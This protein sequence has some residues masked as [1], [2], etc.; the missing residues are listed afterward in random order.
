MTEL[1]STIDNIQLET[2]KIH[3]LNTYIYQILKSGNQQKSSDLLYNIT[4]ILDKIFSHKYGLILSFSSITSNKFELYDAFSHLLTPILGNNENLLWI[5]LHN[6]Q[7][8]SS[9]LNNYIIVDTKQ[10]SSYF[11]YLFM[12]KDQLAVS[13]I[14]SMS[15]RSNLKILENGNKENEGKLRLTPFELYVVYLLKY[16][17]SMSNENRLVDKQDEFFNVNEK[18]FI[19]EYSKHLRLSYNSNLSIESNLLFNSFSELMKYLIINE[20]YFQRHLN[21]LL[22]AANIFL[23]SEPFQINSNSNMI[24]DKQTMPSRLLLS[25]VENLLLILI[26][27]IFSHSFINNK[28]TFI[29]LPTE[30]SEILFLSFRFS[31]FHFIKQSLQSYSYFYLNHNYNHDI[32]YILKILLLY[33]HPWKAFVDNS[34]ITTIMTTD[35]FRKYFERNVFFYI[36]LVQDC[37]LC[38]SKTR[39]TFFE[40][41][42]TF[43]LDF[44]FEIVVSELV[45][46]YLVVEKSGVNS[47][48]F[49]NFN[50]NS[51]LSDL[52]PAC[53][54][55]FLFN[56]FDFNAVK[57]FVN[58]K[59]A[60]QH[61]IKLFSSN[62][63]QLN[64][65]LKQILPLL[66]EDNHLVVK[67]YIIKTI[68]SSDSS[69]SKFPYEKLCLL[70]GIDF[71]SLKTST[72]QNKNQ[73]SFY[74][75]ENKQKIRLNRLNSNPWD[76][77]ITG[78][79]SEIL[80]NFFRLLAFKIEKH[81]LKKDI[82]NE[83]HPFLNLRPLVSIKNLM[84][85]FLIVYLMVMFVKN[86]GVFIK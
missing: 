2:E 30:D 75:Y 3:F 29:F 74:N 79:E 78:D 69:S 34:D 60:N 33:T 50:S 23:L 85:I 80:Y 39:H 9:T 32:Q 62:M 14:S 63:H 7:H 44:D 26:K 40:N 65:N 67:N 21:F 37:L 35:A 41:E 46:C 72:F 61:L 16:I 53:S 48:N 28:H 76:R 71:N 49:G 13:L 36:T 4:T 68:I 15:I 81:I 77:N 83:K 84:F 1:I 20:A 12:N 11:H 57:G 24:K 54:S 22:S 25:C 56:Y 66:I 51:S 82:S 10:I 58:G 70:L 73:R 45:D 86:R 59:L 6:Q 52:S 43:D 55:L 8:D 17:Q 47:K 42:P 27:K 19:S 18:T 64:L 5:L 31:F 38:F